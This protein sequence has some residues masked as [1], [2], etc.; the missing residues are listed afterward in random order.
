MGSSSDIFM[1][2][3]ELTLAIFGNVEVCRYLPPGRGTMLPSARGGGSIDTG[4]RGCIINAEG[5]CQLVG[6]GGG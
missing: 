2:V 1:M 5:V 6:G 4:R 3:V